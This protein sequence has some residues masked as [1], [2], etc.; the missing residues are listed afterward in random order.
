MPMIGEPERVFPSEVNQIPVESSRDLPSIPTMGKANTEICQADVL[1]GKATG[2]QTG[3][4]W[5]PVKNG[6]GT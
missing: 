1:S 3:K 4:L 6:L 2:T 5:R